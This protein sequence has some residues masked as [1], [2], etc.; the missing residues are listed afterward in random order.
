MIFNL[1]VENIHQEQK[2]KE[3]MKP[4]QVVGRKTLEITI[5]IWYAC[6][7]TK[8]EKIQRCSIV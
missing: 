7:M 4:R 2:R 5:D 8:L 6:N 1:I 3:R